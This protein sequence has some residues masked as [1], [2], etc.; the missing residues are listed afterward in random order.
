ME[1]AAPGAGRRSERLDRRVARAGGCAL[2]TI[3]A[4]GAATAIAAG[5]GQTPLDALAHALIVGMPVG[6]GLGAI[7]RLEN[8]RFALLLAAL[9]GLMLIATFGDAG[10]ELAYTVGRTSGWVVELLMV[11]LLLSFPTGRLRSRTDRFLF[12]AMALI[13]LVLFVPRLGIAQD[14]AV[15]SPYTS[16]TQDCPD[17]A[18]FLLAAEPGLV[19][20]FLAPVSALAVIA[21]STAVALRI[22]ERFREATPLARRILAP[23]LAIGVARMALLGLGFAL[24][25]AEPGWWP[26]QTVAWALALS[27]PALALAFL[28]ALVRWQVFAAT[29]LGR[30]AE[31]IRDTTDATALRRALADAFGDP[32][33]T[34]WLPPDPIP[35]PG[36]GRSVTELRDRGAV[37]ATIVHDEA[38]RASPQLLNAGLAMAGVVLDN[39][40]LAAEADV[41]TREVRRSRARIAASAERE[42]RRIERDLHDGAQQHLVALRIELEL[43]EE[44]VLRDP[45]AGIRRLRE[46][47]AQV[48][49]TLEELRSLAHGVYPP[50]LADC[51]LHEALRTAAARSPVPVEVVAHDVGRYPPEVESA[52]YFCVLEALQNVLKHAPSAHRV[53]IRLTGGAASLRFSVRDD[54]TGVGTGAL[55][56]GA[57]MTNMNDRLSAVGGE[58]SVTS[59]RGVGT[60]VEGRVPVS[61]PSAD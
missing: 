59:R 31:W 30:L 17:N 24:R 53:A 18:F 52:V 46:L 22:A 7:G 58:L 54:G 55:R 27:V 32:T 9:G 61:E 21:L 12:G 40:R 47:E 56:P 38:L 26:V 6:V 44:L 10:D 28:V 4:A 43:A 20:G 13:V 36:P 41:A 8:D 23:V 16:C 14:F 42:R 34:V 49:E 39:Q 2:A 48:D 1:L 37:V 19:D 11:Y 45:R 29:A 5:A 50:L 3:A 57:G 15:P 35:D 33:L 25:E 51:G 60:T